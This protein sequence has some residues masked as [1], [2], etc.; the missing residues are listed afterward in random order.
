MLSQSQ[1]N[2]AIVI[3]GSIAGL[4]AARVLLKHFERVTLIERDTYPQEPVS[5]LGFRKGDSSTA[6]SCEVSRL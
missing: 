1:K 3:G 6:L 5:A 2:H 4:V